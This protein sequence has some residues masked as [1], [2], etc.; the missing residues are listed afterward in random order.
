[1]SSRK[2]ASATLLFFLLQLILIPS[3]DALIIKQLTEEEAHLKSLDRGWV[4]TEGNPVE[5]NAVWARMV[6]VIE[7]PPEEV[8]A[9]YIQG[10]DWVDYNI[11]MLRVSRSLSQ[12]FV[13]KFFQKPTNRFKKFQEILDGKTFDEVKNRQQNQLWST[14][15]VQYFDLPWPVENKWFIVQ[16][17]HNE[18]EGKKHLFRSTGL[19]KGGNLKKL[20]NTVTFRPFQGDPQRTEMDYSVLNDTGYPVPKTLLTWGAEQVMPRVIRAI[21]RTLKKKAGQEVEETEPVIPPPP[22]N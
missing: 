14:H 16:H 11:P 8:W 7:A 13:E 3:G 19:L 12:E 20:D 9:I 4:Y 6:G 5:G 21:R 1:M 10:N 17:R 22:Q 15:T 18:T 2:I